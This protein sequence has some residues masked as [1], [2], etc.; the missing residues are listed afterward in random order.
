[1]KVAIAS[2]DGVTIS[3]HFGRSAC[4]I[5]FEAQDGK[6]TNREKRSNTY[7]AFA[8][9]ECDGQGHHAPNA[10]HSHAGIVNALRDCGA[11]LCYGMGWR[12]AEDLKQNGIQA[13]VLAAEMSPE[14][15]VA[16]FAAGKLAPSGVFC[17]CHE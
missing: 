10:T 9:G 1:M 14:E 15:A 12:A 16:A 6:I 7:T 2:E 5:V 8:T 13:F 3:H 17:R 11:V 4:F